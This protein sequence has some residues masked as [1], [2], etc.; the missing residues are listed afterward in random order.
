M[1]ETLF[2][3]LLLGA[4]AGRGGG[5]PETLKIVLFRADCFGVG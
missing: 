5:V 1:F 4:E 3:K 2:A